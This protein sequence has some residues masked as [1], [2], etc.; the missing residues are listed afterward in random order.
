MKQGM[1]YPRALVPG[2]WLTLTLTVCLIACGGSEDFGDDAGQAGADEDSGAAARDA[3]ADAAAGP[4][5][6]G[7]RDS[8]FPLVDGAS[9]TYRH[10]D[11]TE[12][13]WDEV[14]TLTA[15]TYEGKPAFLM[16]DQEDNQG[17]ES[18]TTLVVD[19]TRIYRVKKVISVAGS[20]ALEVIYDPGFL[21]FDE[22]WTEVGDMTISPSERTETCFKSSV[23]SPCVQ[24]SA[25]PATS[26]HIF[27]V[28]STAAEVTV[29]AG[30]FTT[31]QFER[32][33]AGGE[34]KQF[35]F[36]PGVGKVLERNNKSGATE[37]LVDY[38]IP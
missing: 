13:S 21:R 7:S 28:L 37:E 23:A 24:G 31:L 1:S 6:A 11:P 18:R 10:N 38:D 12:G 4:P 35:W 15:S 17:E 29:A 26:T 14:A 20:K 9:F 34:I 3:G 27:R 25:V 33:N 16:D 8:H 5:E 19:G 22:A 32:N 30:T 36:A 2:P